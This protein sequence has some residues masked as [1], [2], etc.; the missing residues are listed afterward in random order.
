MSS[1]DPDV[2]EPARWKGENLLGK[3]LMQ[4]RLEVGKTTEVEALKEKLNKLINS[5]LIILFLINLN[6]N[7]WI[8]EKHIYSFYYFWLT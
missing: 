5:K 3:A 8:I 1:R 2:F 4:V 7:K 6:K